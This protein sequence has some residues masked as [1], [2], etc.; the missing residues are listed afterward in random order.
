MLKHE[1][2]QVL[3]LYHPSQWRR[4]FQ[5]AIYSALDCRSSFLSNVS[6][7]VSLWMK[8]WKSFAS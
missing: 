5:V 4:Y 1:I 7:D 3:L 8:A 2:V 6:W